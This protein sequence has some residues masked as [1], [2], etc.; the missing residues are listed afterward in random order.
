[1]G[2]SRPGKVGE[3]AT[4]DRQHVGSVEPEGFCSPSVREGRFRRLAP[5]L[6]DRGRLKSKPRQ[7][8]ITL[9]ANHATSEV[10]AKRS[11]GHRTDFDVVSITNQS[12]LRETWPREGLTP[13]SIGLDQCNPCS[14]RALGG[15]RLPTLNSSCTADFRGSP[16]LMRQP[17]GAGSRVRTAAVAWEQADN[18]QTGS[19]W[20]LECSCSRWKRAG[21]FKEGAFTRLVADSDPT[22]SHTQCIPI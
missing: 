21:R 17:A 16:E 8:R 5:Y 19:V 12:A 1:M 13:R 6:L 10:V 15:E 20:K 2:G 7:K 22:Q 4:G 14:P 3:Q 11:L 9:Q 18:V